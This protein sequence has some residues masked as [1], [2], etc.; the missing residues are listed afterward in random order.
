[1]LKELKSDQEWVRL[2]AITALDE[3]GAA[4]KPALEAVREAQKDSNEY[5]RR[6]AAHVLEKS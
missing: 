1:M 6:V 4:A 5:V 3:A 2:H